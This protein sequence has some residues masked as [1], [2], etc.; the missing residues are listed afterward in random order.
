MDPQ[1]IREFL[2]NRYE[3]LETGESPDNR[4]V[5]ST[6]CQFWLVEGTLVLGPVWHSDFPFWSC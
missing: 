5:P 6:L 1:E 3:P 2:R 4:W